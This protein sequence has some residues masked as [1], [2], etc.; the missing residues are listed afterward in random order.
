MVCY[1]P[2]ANTLPE[3]MLTHYQ[4]NVKKHLQ[5]RFV[6]LTQLFGKYVS[7]FLRASLYDTNIKIYRKNES[8]VLIQPRGTRSRIMAGIFK[9]STVIMIYAILWLAGGTIMEVWP[10]MRIWHKMKRH[11]NMCEHCHSLAMI[12][13]KQGHLKT[14]DCIKYQSGTWHI[15]GCRGCTSLRCSL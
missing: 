14:N 15:V 5:W 7:M 12:N 8:F 4:L 13:R 10:I 3:L 1:L 9:E 2:I 11:Y 6:Y